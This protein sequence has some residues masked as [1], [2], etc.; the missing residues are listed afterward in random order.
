M[1]FYLF[2]RENKTCYLCLKRFFFSLD[3]TSIHRD[4]NTESLL[5]NARGFTSSVVVI[6]HISALNESLL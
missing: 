5:T 3:F 2:V 4:I 1:H 6:S